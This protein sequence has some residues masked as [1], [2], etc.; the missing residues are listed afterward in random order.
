MVRYLVV[1]L[2]F[3]LEVAPYIPSSLGVHIF[4]VAYVDNHIHF[5]PLV[6]QKLFL[7]IE[8]ALN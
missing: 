7:P 6:R 4:E 5:P 3:A 2:C 8:Y 1:S